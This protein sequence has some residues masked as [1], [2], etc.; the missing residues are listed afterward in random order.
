MNEQSLQVQGL[1]KSFGDRPLWSGISFTLRSGEILALR[2]DSGSGKSTLLNAIGMLTGVNAGTVSYAGRRLHVG[3]RD[4]RRIRVE[5]IGFLFQDYGLVEDATVAENL[6]IAA[7]PRI[8]SPRR[9]YSTT[10]A[11]FG[12][13]GRER[14]RVYLLSGGE[15]QRLAL[16]RLCVRPTPIVLADE[17]T[18]ALDAG[19]AEVVLETLREFAGEGR[20]VILATHSDEV[21]AIATTTLWLRRG[22]YDVAGMPAR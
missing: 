15:Q 5:T 12:L 1:T 8:F 22:E 11:R 4:S 6:D 2:G 17:P 19:N 21:A 10:L 7:R 13:A 20:I 16:A 3:R 18:A 14:S 9:D